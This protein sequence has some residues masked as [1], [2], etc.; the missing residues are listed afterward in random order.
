MRHR[1]DFPL[2]WRHNGRDS[3][4][5]HQPHDCLL[6]VYS[7]TDQRKHQSSASLAF[8]AGNSPGTGEFPA[9]MA[10]YA[11][12]V[13]IWWR[14]HAKL[15]IRIWIRNEISHNSSIIAEA[16]KPQAPSIGLG[17]RA[18]ESTFSDSFS[19]MKIDVFWF[20]YHWKLFPGVD[21]QNTASNNIRV[22]HRTS[23]E[24]VM[25]YLSGVYALHLATKN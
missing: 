11:E 5:N 12:N 9:Q 19:G 7:D 10:S 20:R 21:E 13:S 16:R 25:V 8:C 6:N 24:L 22:F 14:H 23:F 15:N 17:N 1:L 3:V 18:V 2:L 4:S